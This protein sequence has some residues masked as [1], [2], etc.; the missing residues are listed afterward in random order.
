MF[1]S[2]AGSDSDGLASRSPKTISQ[3]SQS[4]KAHPSLYPSAHTGI[5]PHFHLSFKAWL[6]CPLLREASSDWHSPESPSDLRRCVAGMIARKCTF[7]TGL[8]SVLSWFRPVAFSPQQVPLANQPGPERFCVWR[9]SS[10]HSGTS[11]H[12]GLE[13]FLG[14]FIL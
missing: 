6:E 10:D 7:H 8:E 4:P 3:S 11:L 9:S 5:L 13:S 12:P 1:L 2:T 14:S